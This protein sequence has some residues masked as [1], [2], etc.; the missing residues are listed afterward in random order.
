MLKIMDTTVSQQAV[1]CDI[2]PMLYDCIP[3]VRLNNGLDSDTTVWFVIGV[4]YLLAVLHM[5]R[6]PSRVQC[7]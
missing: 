5:Q 7:Q 4:H 6:S 1:L 3:V 2:E